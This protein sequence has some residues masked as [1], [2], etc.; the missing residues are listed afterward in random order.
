MNTLR[1]YV[2][3]YFNHLTNTKE[4][5]INRMTYIFDKIHSTDLPFLNINEESRK[6]FKYK[7]IKQFNLYIIRDFIQ[8]NSHQIATKL[9]RTNQKERY[10]DPYEEV[11]ERMLFRKELYAHGWSILQIETY[12]SKY[13]LKQNL[14]LSTEELNYIHVLY[15]T[16][17]HRDEMVEQ[18]ITVGRPSLPTTIKEYVKQKR[19][20]HI[21]EHMQTK[22]KNA[23]KYKELKD[24]VLTQEELESCK[25]VIQSREI[26]EKLETLTNI[27]RN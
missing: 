7:P 13:V 26:I 24:L 25:Q 8:Y 14:T 20:Q 12:I 11:T 18:K 17:L 10:T 19:I 4:Q 21:K 9:N 3:E 1:T 27:L 2:E 22:Y 16:V 5:F 15:T 23:H 6:Q